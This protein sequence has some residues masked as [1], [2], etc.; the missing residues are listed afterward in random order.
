MQTYQNQL[1]ESEDSTIQIKM[2]LAPVELGRAFLFKPQ[3]KKPASDVSPAAAG[4]GQ[5]AWLQQIQ[6][7][8]SKQ[9]RTSELHRRVLTLALSWRPLQARMP[10]A[11][12]RYLF[13][14]I[15][16]GGAEGGARVRH[17]I[18]CNPL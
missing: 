16:G 18:P 7:Q 17:N 2:E 12:I 3:E 13:F 5:E 14:L 11:E 6:H 15:P 8:R 10:L 9:E 4:S 1:D